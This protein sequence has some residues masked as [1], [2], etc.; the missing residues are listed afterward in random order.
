ML[1]VF[2]M[3]IWGANYSVIK[4]GLDS[5]DPF[6][7]TA[8]R[9]FLCALPAIFFVKPP[10]GKMWAAVI[11]GLIFGIGLWGMVNLGMYWG[12]PA[13]LAAVLLQFSAF[14][15]ILWGMLFFNDALK[16]GQAIGILIALVGFLII[17]ATSKGWTA[18]SGVLLIILAAFS[19]SLC[20]I[21]IK[22]T[23]PNNLLPFIIWSS[24]FSAA[25]LFLLTYCIK[26]ALP[27]ILLPDELNKSAVFSLFFQA[28]V[29][30]I[31][32]YWVW[33]FLIKKYSAT[34]VAPLSML[35]P[36]F[37]FAGAYGMFHE[38]LSPI[39]VCGAVV[40]LAGMALFLLRPFHR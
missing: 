13:G 4:V 39:K 15:T 1:G 9:F 40:M 16:P 21:I 5:L 2:V 6:M 22:K 36:V 31:F 37:G 30:T 17:I 11:Y 24:L 8:L 3:M 18:L 23:Q 34:E 27:F 33:S 7:L 38:V 14:F 25:P 10:R 32:G 29:T 26:G 19:W 20:N 12:V 35:I 28:Y